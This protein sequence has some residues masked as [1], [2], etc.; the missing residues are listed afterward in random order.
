[1]R[2][3][4]WRITLKDLPNEGRAWEV[5]VPAAELMDAARGKVAPLAEM[6]GDLAF[7]GEIRRKGDVW[8]LVG[9]WRVRIRRVCDR[10]LEP[11][12]WEVSG[13]F[14]RNYRLAGVVEDAFDEEALAWPGEVD[15]VDVLREEVWLA[16]R[17]QVVCASDC[18]G[19]CPH[20][21]ANR[22]HE[23]CACVDASWEHPFAAL[24]ALV[25]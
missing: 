23:D 4:A 11:F 10:C 25:E 19:L 6:L 9:R 12:A 21:G 24:K 16:W 3:H 2:S 1:M 13:A 7:A 18:K 14:E 17:P 20:C 15:L 5:D 22:N 8:R